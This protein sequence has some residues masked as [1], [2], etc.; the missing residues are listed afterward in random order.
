MTISRRIAALLARPELDTGRLVE[1]RER[2][3]SAGGTIRDLDLID[4]AAR[5]PHPVA[6][7]LGVAAESLRRRANSALAAIDAAESLRLWPGSARAVIIAATSATDT[8][9]SAIAALVAT[10]HDSPSY[11]EANPSHLRNEVARLDARARAASGDIAVAVSVLVDVVSQGGSVEVWPALLRACGSDLAP[12][13]G[14]LGLAL[15]TDGDEFMTTLERSV[16]PARSATICASYLQAGGTNP[17]AVTT[18]ILAA[19]MS[20]QD[21][22]ALVIAD[23]ASLLP[24]EILDRLG[25]HLGENG[26]PAIAE[27]LQQVCV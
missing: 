24:D 5:H 1:A 8:D 17:D 12:P 16:E 25:A 27:R 23:H 3:T 15:L 6:V 7:A 21:Q 4:D 22:L 18:G 10:A 19:A 14:V 9:P 20:G 2:Y 13:A 11:A 26:Q